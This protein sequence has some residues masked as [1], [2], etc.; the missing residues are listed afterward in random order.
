MSH[1]PRH[2]LGPHA[3]SSSSLIKPMRASNDYFPDIPNSH[4][5]HVYTNLMASQFL[6]CFT[7]TDFDM[8][9]THPSI[10]NSGAPKQGAFHASLRALGNGPVTITDVPERCNRDIFMRLCG[11]TR[12]G[13]AIALNAKDPI[14]ILDERCFDWV[15]EVGD[16]KGIR[17][18]SRS[19]WGVCMGIWNVRESH[20]WVRDSV[21]LD[22]TVAVLGSDEIVYWSH[23]KKEVIQMKMD[24]K[25]VVL[26]E[27][28]FDV[29]TLVELTSD[30]VCLGLVDKYNTLAAI[31]SRCGNTWEFKCL[32]EA[33][34]VIKGDR[35]AV[36]KVEGKSISTLRYKVDDLTVLRASLTDFKEKE[37]SWKSSWTVDVSII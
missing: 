5:Y 2:L 8:F 3:L 23:L 15:N 34:W 9:Q 4:A 29:L 26:G 10:N 30:I 21:S 16:G 12:D 37:T 19:V 20:G 28:E 1:S 31:E 27:L 11:L 24:P 22:D 25:E 7:I 33:V 18:Y 13:K 35:R 17:G 32:G 6:S 36:V 14:E